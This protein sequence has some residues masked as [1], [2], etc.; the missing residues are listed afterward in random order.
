M[1][2][3]ATIGTVQETLGRNYDGNAPLERWIRRAAATVARVIACATENGVTLSD[4]E[5]LLLEEALAAYYYTKMDP[6]YSSKSTSNGMGSASGSFVG[7][8]DCPEWY[9]DLAISLDP[10]GCLKGI[11]SGVTAKGFWPGRYPA[12][13]TSYDD[14]NV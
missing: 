5:K 9:K 12:S 10:S 2:Y 8:P 14:R 7:N 3:G 4:E 13:Q 1:A 11:L 6:M